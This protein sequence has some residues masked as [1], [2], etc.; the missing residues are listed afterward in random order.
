MT[1][2]EELKQELQKCFDIAQIL[3]MKNPELPAAFTGT[4][5]ERIRRQLIYLGVLEQ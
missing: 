5:S 1:P 3:D 4:P 2:E